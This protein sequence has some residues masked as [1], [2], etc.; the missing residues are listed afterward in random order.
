[1]SFKQPTSMNM[2]CIYLHWP[3]NHCTAQVAY[4]KSARR[5]TSR[6][7]EAQTHRNGTTAQQGNTNRAFEA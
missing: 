3:L 2:V 6:G 1:M 5:V 4:G 7:R